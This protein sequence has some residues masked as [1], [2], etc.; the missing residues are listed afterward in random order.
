VTQ[1][2]ISRTAPPGT[3]GVP[4]VD[5][6]GIWSR[7]FD[8]TWDAVT[9]TAGIEW[10]P[11]DDS[12]GFL[13][14]SRGYKAGGFNTG[15]IT[16]LPM[17]DPEF[18]NAYE[19]GWKQQL[20]GRLQLNASVFFYDYKDMQIPLT[21]IPPAGPPQTPFVNLAKVESTG[22]EIE[23]IWAPID[24]LQVLFNY[25]YLNA[26]VKEACCFVDGVDTGAVQP[27]AQPSG[28]R[29]GTNQ[30]QTLV[31]QTVPQSPK[32]KAALNVNYTFHFAAGSLNVG[33]TDIWKDETY[34]SVFNRWYNLAPSYNQV[35]A[36]ATWTSEDNRYSLIAYGRNILDEDGYD[37]AG[38]GYQNQI[39]LGGPNLR[40]IP[41]A[42]ARNYSLT[43]PATFGMEV[44]YRF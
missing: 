2:L 42:I 44:Q 24:D 21:Y 41:R 33:A 27:E 9:G 28:P 20:G 37:G 22:F 32:H 30:G 18:V 1:A 12:L 6:A 13:K 17:T 16:A 26:E 19:L 25:A 31:G 14:Y 39:P 23:T 43:P 11:M 15:T 29:S 4:T 36:R 40:T 7:G 34:F 3:T 38:A 5:A 8:Q 35:D 10:R